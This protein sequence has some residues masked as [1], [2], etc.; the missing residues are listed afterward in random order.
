[1][2]GPTL[3]ITLAT[4]AA[5]GVINLWLAGTL[6][7]LGGGVPMSVDSDVIGGIGVAGSG[8]AATD[9][10]CATAAIA[11]GLAPAGARR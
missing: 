11:Q 5:S 8:G 6:P 10:R 1:M 3:S 9:E 2:T 4:A 7:L